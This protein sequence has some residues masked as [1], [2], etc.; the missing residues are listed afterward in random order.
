MEA[1]MRALPP[2]A[3]RA[4]LDH[5]PRYTFFRPRVGEGPTTKMGVAAVDGRTIAV[6][7]GLPHGTAAFLD[8]T[9]PDGTPLRRLVLAEDTGGGIRGARVDLFWGRDDE[10]RLQAGRMKQRGRLYFLVPR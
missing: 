6:D 9:R 2:A 4:L 7:P 1:H 10:A 3:L 8:T 5:N